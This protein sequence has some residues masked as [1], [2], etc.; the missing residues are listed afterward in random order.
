MQASKP[1]QADR[2]YPAA[3]AENEVGK[4][5]EPVMRTRGVFSTKSTSNKSVFA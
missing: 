1:Q 4:C 5:I 3:I 2:E